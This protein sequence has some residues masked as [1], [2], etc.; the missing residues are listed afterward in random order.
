MKAFR[1]LALLV[2]LVVLHTTSC[3][4][5]SE[6]ES[7][8]PSATAEQLAANDGF[9]PAQAADL[10]ERDFVHPAIASLSYADR[11]SELG[12]VQ[13]AG[14]TWVLSEL[15]DSTQQNLIASGIAGPELDPRSGEVLLLDEQ[16]VLRAVVLPGIPPTFIAAG[17][18]S[19]FVGRIGDGGYPDSALL[20]VNVPGH[21]VDR[22]IF[23]QQTIDPVA[24]GDAWVVGSDSQFE[25]FQAAAY[26]EV[27]S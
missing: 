7:G 4:A 2:C 20:R 21:S 1:S 3:A 25:L 5:D 13:V 24:P 6:P 17:D 18:Q 14:E 15:P 16:Q 26:D 23:Q 11:V 9:G 19:V 22:V 27:F 10:A 12:R 8:S